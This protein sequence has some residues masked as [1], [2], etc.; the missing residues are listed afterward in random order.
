[1][2]ALNTLGIAHRFI[3]EHL[4]PGGFCIDAT[5]GRG[6]DTAFLC[7]IVGPAGRVLAFDIQFQY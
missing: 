3:Q 4:S 1:M 5:A 6:Y 2:P 7:Q